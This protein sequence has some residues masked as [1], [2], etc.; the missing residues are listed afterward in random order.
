MAEIDKKF[1]TGIFELL[2][3]HDNN[4][5]NQT[6]TKKGLEAMRAK[7]Y[8]EVQPRMLNQKQAE[9]YTGMGRN[10]L[11]EFARKI[12]ARRKI[13]RMVLY[14][15]TVIDAGLDALPEESAEVTAI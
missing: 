8:Q 2:H 7:A 6:D 15:R 13:G 9:A 10:S 12:G 11:V 1:I 5:I 14:D 4:N 3:A